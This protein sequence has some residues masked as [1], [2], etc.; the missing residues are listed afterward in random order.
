MD[1]K[2]AKIEMKD[3]A[4][5]RREEMKRRELRAAVPMMSREE[6]EELKKEIAEAE[7]IDPSQRGLAI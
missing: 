3:T 4:L 6:L 1:F 7:S 5:G 2:N